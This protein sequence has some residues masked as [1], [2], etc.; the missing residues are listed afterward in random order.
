M[1]NIIK[2]I[3][4]YFLLSLSTFSQNNPSLFTQTMEY[5]SWG[6]NIIFST[7]SLFLS[8][9]SESDSCNIVNNSNQNV[10]LDSIYNKTFSMYSCY[11]KTD[12]E[13]FYS[14]V[15]SYDESNSLHIRLNPMDTVKFMIVGVDLCPICKKQHDEYLRDTLVFVFTSD[16]NQTTEKSL[17]LNSDISLDVEDDNINVNSFY[18]SQNYP[19]P[20]N[21]STKIKYSI[22]QPGLITLKVYDLLGNEIATLVNEEKTV[23]SYEINFDAKILSSGVYFYIMRVGNFTDTKKFILLK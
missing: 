15:P 13:Y 14:N 20:F 7:D 3:I 19:N 9:Y 5:S 8:N 10:Y 4:V 17:L 22:N 23:G 16:S 6:E 21:P 1:K 12:S 2:I 18:L 11:I